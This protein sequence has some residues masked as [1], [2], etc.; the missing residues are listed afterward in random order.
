L[1]FNVDVI[2]KLLAPVITTILGLIV[3]AYVEGEAE[4]NYLSRSRIRDSPWG[5]AEHKCKLPQC[6]R[7]KLREKDC[8]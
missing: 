6:C 4:A 7:K 3:K 5:P 1:D 8:E 2:A